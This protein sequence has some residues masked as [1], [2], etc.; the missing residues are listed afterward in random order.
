MKIILGLI[1]I[2]ICVAI[3][4]SYGKKLLRESNKMRYSDRKY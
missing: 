4:W 3:G 2:A 1:V